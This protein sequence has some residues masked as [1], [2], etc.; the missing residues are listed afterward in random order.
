MILIV[1]TEYNFVMKE[2]GE[3]THFPSEYA[4]LSPISISQEFVKIF[5]LITS[6]M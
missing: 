5:Y 2:G 6:C 1:F 4:Y 3:F